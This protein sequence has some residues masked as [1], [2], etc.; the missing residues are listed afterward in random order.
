MTVCIPS[1]CPAWRVAA[2]FHRAHHGVIQP[3]TID[4][5]HDCGC[6]AAVIGM[7]KVKCDTPSFEESR[8]C[9]SPTLTMMPT[10]S[11]ICWYKPAATLPGKY[12]AIA[13]RWGL[14]LHSRAARLWKKILVNVEITII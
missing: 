9:F 1:S 13:G 8:V 2:G 12:R 3:M 10:Q 6:R 5:L 11:D 14:H 7:D 4:T